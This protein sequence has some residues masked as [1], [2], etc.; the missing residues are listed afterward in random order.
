VLEFYRKSPLPEVGVASLSDEEFE[1]LEAFLPVLS[2]P[3]EM[4]KPR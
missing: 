4:R 2:G 1:E 3:V